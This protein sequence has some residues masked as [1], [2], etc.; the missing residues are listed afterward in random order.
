MSIFHGTANVLPAN[1]TFFKKY[2]WNPTPGNAVLQFL[3]PRLHDRRFASDVARRDRRRKICKGNGDEQQPE[4]W[5]HAFAGLIR[6]TR[7]TVR[8]AAGVARDVGF[9][10]S[11]GLLGWPCQRGRT[12]WW[13]M[14]KA[15]NGRPISILSNIDAET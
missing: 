12:K 15:A 5:T 14:T 9:Y 4:I 6:I 10:D 11:P 3:S 2:E 13:V 8:G 7:L 1:C